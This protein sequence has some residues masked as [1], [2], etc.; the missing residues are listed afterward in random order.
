MYVCGKAVR[1]V[2]VL[3]RGAAVPGLHFPEL[4]IKLAVTDEY[5]GYKRIDAGQVCLVHLLRRAKSCAIRNGKEKHVQLYV[6]L[7]HA[8]RRIRGIMAGEVTI[9]E[10]ERQVLEIADGYWK[11]HEMRVALTNALPRMLTFLSHPGMPCKND[12]AEQAIRAGPA[13]EKKLCRRPRSAEGMRCLS[14]TCSVF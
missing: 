9:R 1:V 13:K 7:R 10:L 12:G 14:V 2:F 5:S 4:K 8:C 11:E 6:R 3:S